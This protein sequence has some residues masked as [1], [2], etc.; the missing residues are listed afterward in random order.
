M[1]FSSPGFKRRVALQVLGEGQ[2]LGA[3]LARGR[4]AG[5][6]RALLA[7]DPDDDAADAAPTIRET[8]PEVVALA[9][10]IHGRV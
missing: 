2:L 3:G 10:D 6:G 9:R 5:I 1:R 7:V 4:A 8:D